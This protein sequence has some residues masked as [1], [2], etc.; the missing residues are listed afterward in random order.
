[1][2]NLEFRVSTKVINY[3]RS[4]KKIDVALA[5][6]LAISTVIG[7]LCRLSFSGYN[8]WVYERY[9]ISKE[10]QKESRID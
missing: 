7:L 5:E 9:I 3:E 1:M 2:F 8:N 4:Y 10:M 6:V